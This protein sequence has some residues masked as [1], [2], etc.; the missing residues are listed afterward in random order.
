[1]FF[2]KKKGHSLP[3][4]PNGGMSYEGRAL[5]DIW[6]AGGCFWGVE[7]Y[8]CRIAGVAETSVG[9]ANGS[10]K[11]PT[12]EEVCTGGTGHAETVQ[13]RFDQERVSLQA[14]L[15]Q[16]FTIIDPTVTNRQGN[17]RGT[18]YRTGIYYADQADRAAIDEAV[19]EEQRKHNKPIVTEVLPLK[20]YYVAEE[21]HQDYL[22]KNPGGYCH[23]DFSSL[24]AATPPPQ[25]TRYAK[26]D[27]A[28]LRQRLTPEQYAV[29][30]QS[31]TEPPFQNEYWDHSAPG[32]YV[33]IVTG[34]PLFSSSD[35]FDS[36]C[37]WPSF[38]KPV[39][40]DAVVDLED[41]S[42]GRKR[43]EVRSLG[44]SHLGHVFEDGPTALGGLRYCINSA[45]LR[46]IPLSAMEQEGYGEYIKLI[47]GEHL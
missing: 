46:F 33:D 11:N 29:T 3:P 21:Y 12:Y 36:G 47:R 8:M 39:A 25:D 6:L 45:S 27:D 38:T 7:A 9:Y 20:A 44:D 24:E 31:A 13:V 15:R 42:L 26:P 37:G 1:M 43:V 19:A 35:K 30:Q 16:F 40:A 34:Q 32:L 28:T 22:E 17:D 14:I 10:T 5:R 23:V 18:Q 2:Q 41:K 4:N